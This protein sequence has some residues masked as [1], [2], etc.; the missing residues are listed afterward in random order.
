VR[1]E[2][3]LRGTREATFSTC[4][5]PTVF[6]VTHTP[7]TSAVQECLGDKSTA[8][9]AHDGLCCVVPRC[10]VLCRGELRIYLRDKPLL[11][12]L[13]AYDDDRDYE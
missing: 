2:N 11:P 4:S 9:I 8:S 1:G 13:P 3:L 7:Q 5:Q 6:S 10:A 12:S